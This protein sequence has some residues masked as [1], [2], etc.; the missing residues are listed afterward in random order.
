MNPVVTT[1]P[2]VDTQKLKRKEHK[3]TSKEN[4]QTK[5]RILPNPCLHWNP[6]ENFNQ[7]VFLMEGDGG[8]IT[9]L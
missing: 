7:L 3:Y 4:H 1:K 6:R 8:T 2:T 5:R 9:T